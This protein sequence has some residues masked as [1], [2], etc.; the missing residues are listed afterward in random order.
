MF[1]PVTDLDCIECG[2]PANEWAYDGTDPT[3]RVWLSEGKYAVR[4]SVWPEFYMPM[5]FGCHRKRDA[6]IRRLR[7]SS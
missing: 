7:G 1:G 6:G 2:G 5:C 3:E 4:Y